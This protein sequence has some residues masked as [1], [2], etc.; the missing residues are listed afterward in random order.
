MTYPLFQQVL[1]VLEIEG[2]HLSAALSRARADGK[3]TTR[4]AVSLWA[5]G[6]RPPSAGV[7]LHLRRLSIEKAN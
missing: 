2:A 7:M 6:H 5:N 4:A 1:D 3:E